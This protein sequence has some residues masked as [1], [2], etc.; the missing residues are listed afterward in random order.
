MKDHTDPIQTQTP[1]TDT[2]ASTTDTAIGTAAAIS[3]SAATATAAATD[4]A[5]SS[6]P[7]GAV[8]EIQLNMW[9]Q[10]YRRVFTICVTDFGEQ[11]VGYFR[12]PDMEI[13]SA[14]NK[15]NKTDEIKAVDVLFTNCFLGGSPL[16]QQE[17]VVKMAAMTVF[18]QVIAVQH[19][20]IKNA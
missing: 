12:R 11:H 18:N 1:A 16:I 14:T 8:D 9:R 15:L 3:A 4:T 2:A 7:I 19:V 17:A 13:L 5:A 20:E 10:R 6:A